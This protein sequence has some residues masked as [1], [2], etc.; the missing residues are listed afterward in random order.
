[1]TVT[2][3]KTGTVQSMSDEYAQRRLQRQ[4]SKS[5]NGMKMSLAK[6]HGDSTLYAP[7]GRVPTHMHLCTKAIVNFNQ[8]K[9]IL[10][11]R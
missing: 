10:E 4:K 1:M 2:Q 8:A 9:F 6:V 3:K 5:Y 11:V 7:K